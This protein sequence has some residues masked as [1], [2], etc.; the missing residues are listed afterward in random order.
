MNY[1]LQIYN[2]DELLDNVDKLDEVMDFVHRVIPDETFDRNDFTKLYGNYAL[3]KNIYMYYHND[4]LIGLSSCNFYNDSIKEDEVIVYLMVIAVDPNYQNNGIG[5]RF[6]KHILDMNNQSNIWIKIHKT[7][8]QSQRFFK[9]NEFI[10]VPKKKIPSVLNPS[11]R[12]P[13]DIYVH[14]MI[15]S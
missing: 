10:K 2:Q 13:Y 4:Q 15:S 9:K 5:S 7:N 6:L 1:K 8:M 12:K 14:K 3:Y 11:Y